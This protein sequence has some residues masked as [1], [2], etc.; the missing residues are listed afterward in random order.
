MAQHSALPAVGDAAHRV[1]PSGGRDATLP[2]VRRE[3]HAPLDNH[4]GAGDC[5]T[6]R[7]CATTVSHD[8]T[9]CRSPAHSPQ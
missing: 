9:G 5:F 4:K 2:L 3:A 1:F 7:R 6:L 8:E